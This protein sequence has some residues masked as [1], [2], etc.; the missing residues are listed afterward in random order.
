M[1]LVIGMEESESGTERDKKATRKR[2]RR[3]SRQER[4]RKDMEKKRRQQGG[5][6]IWGGREGNK[7]EKHELVILKKWILDFESRNEMKMVIA[8]RS[9]EEMEMMME[10]VV[11]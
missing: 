10:V 6:R 11:R 1:R 5:G 3:R 8:M 9:R 4:E 2:R 7:R